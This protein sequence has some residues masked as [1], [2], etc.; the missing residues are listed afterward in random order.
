MSKCRKLEHALKSGKFDEYI[1]DISKNM[2]EHLTEC[3]SCRQLYNELIKTENLVQNTG[4]VMLSRRAKARIRMNIVDGISAPALKPAIW[5]RPVL[6][7]VSAAMII[8]LLMMYPV[9][10][11][12]APD[13]TAVSLQLNGEIAR[14]ILDLIDTDLS[15]Y[16]DPNLETAVIMQSD[17]EL[18]SIALE[19]MYTPAHYIY[20]DTFLAALSDLEETEW[21]LLRRYMI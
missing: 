18:V 8:F 20:D 16:N 14:E 15:L 10:Q 13:E 4:Q 5:F 7:V 2:H 21:S 17:T 1:G 6:G 19:T 11:K 12:P 9:N 3:V